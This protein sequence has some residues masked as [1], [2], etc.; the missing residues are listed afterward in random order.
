MLG[1]VSI[2]CADPASSRAFY[3]AVLAPLGGKALI[4]RGDYVGFGSSFDGSLLFIG[5]VDTIERAHTDVHIAFTARSRAEVEDFVEAA[6]AGGA[7]VLHEAQE[8]SYRPGYYGGFVRD[9]DGNNVEAV[10]WP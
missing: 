2:Q 10:H 7:E 3:E 8:W 4:V 6:R 9:P 5:P 1:H